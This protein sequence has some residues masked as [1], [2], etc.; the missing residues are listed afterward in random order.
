MITVANCP[1]HDIGFIPMVHHVHIMVYYEFAVFR[2]CYKP[3]T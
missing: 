3:S 2:F 1:Y